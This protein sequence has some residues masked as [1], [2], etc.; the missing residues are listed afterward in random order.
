MFRRPPRST[1]FPYT[2]L[3]RSLKAIW[4]WF[5]GTHDGTL[6]DLDFQPSPKVWQQV[7]S[8]SEI[9]TARYCGVRGDCFFQEARKEALEAQAV[10]VNHTLFFSLLDP[11]APAE[12]TGFLFPN[13][14]VV[15][16]EAHTLESV[17][18]NQLGLRMSQAGLRFD[19][20][21]L[22]NPRSE[23]HTSE[24]PSQAYPVRRP[25]P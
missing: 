18:S 8:E 14:F 16:D 19:L 15:F 21:R 23:E 11:D 24:R 7:C 4:K 20:Q 25:P 9:C 13:D 5:E 2:T 3:F 6:S 10:V 17:A 22:Y 1:L 12:E